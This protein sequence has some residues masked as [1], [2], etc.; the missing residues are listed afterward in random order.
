[1]NRAALAVLVTATAV[2]TGCGTPSGPAPEPS[3]SD[4]DAEK[5]TGFTGLD[6]PK[7]ASDLTVTTKTTDD[8][9]KRMAATFRTDRKGA[10]AFCDAE[11]LG[12]Y[13]DPDGPSDED[14]KAF[15]ATGKTVD[16][17]LSCRGADPN[18]GTVQREVLVLYPAKDKAEVHVLAYEFD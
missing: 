7:S 11:N 10:E 9:R 12:T 15:D 8:E 1:M 13:P 2:L 14:R 17:S 6:L 18:S 5:L 4:P 16:G 3:P